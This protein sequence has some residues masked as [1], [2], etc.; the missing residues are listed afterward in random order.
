VLQLA[1]DRETIF[2]SPS[3]SPSLLTPYCHPFLVCAFFAYTVVNF[4]GIGTILHHNLY[5]E[6]IV[7]ISPITS[8][9]TLP[10]SPICYEGSSIPSDE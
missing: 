10:T 6:W 2:P 3:I 8:L 1:K 4:I 7:L 9:D 5:V